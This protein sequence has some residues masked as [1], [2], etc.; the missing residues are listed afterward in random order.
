[1]TL[2]DRNY[3]IF[4]E[5]VTL[6]LKRLLSSG[7]A[8]FPVPISITAVSVVL[9]VKPTLTG[10]FPSKEEE[11]LIKSILL[12]VSRSPFLVYHVQIIILFKF[13]QRWRYSNFDKNTT[14]K[15]FGILLCVQVVIY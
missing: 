2:Q 3:N 7:K 8:G 12:K 14:Q 11:F 4:V 10:L 1:M 13:V 9:E 15:M 5:K 6:L